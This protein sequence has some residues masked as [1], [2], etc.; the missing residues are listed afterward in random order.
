MSTPSR[1]ASPGWCPPYD[2]RVDIALVP[3]TPGEFQ[4]L[5]ARTGWGSLDE[6]TAARALAGSW[7][8]CTARDDDGVLHGVG[9]VISDG[10]MHAYVNEMI[11][12]PD[13]RGQGIGSAII[14]ALVDEVHRRGVD[15]IQLFAAEGRAPFYS[16][17]GFVARPTTAPGMEINPASAL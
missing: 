17:H 14:S 13:S 12:H 6:D 4:D 16:R 9:R 5:F 15:W 3:P 1:G 7:I 11:V 2:A 10:A 8:V